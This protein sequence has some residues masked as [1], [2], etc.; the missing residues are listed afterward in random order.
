MAT[1]TTTARKGSTRS[2]KPKGGG[3][4]Q[5]PALGMVCLSSDRQVKFR[6]ITRS[7]FLSL[8]PAER[9]AQLREIYWCNV[10]ML[11]WALTYCAERDIR[12]YRATSA[13]FPM[14]DEDLGEALL[15]GMASTM[16]SVGR[17]AERLGIRV[18]LHPDQFVV[19][20]SEAE[21]VRET[22]RKVMEKHALAFD[23]LGLERSAWNLMNVHGGKAGR[24]DELVEAIEALPENVRSRLT[25]E[26]DEYSFS[27]AQILDVCRRA[28]VPFVF[29]CHHHVIKECLD[30]YDHPSV[31]EMTAAA[32][33]T[34]PKAAWQLCHISNGHAA[35]LDRY[36][37]EHITIAPGAFRDVPWLE[38][39]ARGKEQAILAL[40]AKWP[41]RA[42]RRRG[43]PLTKPTAAEKRAA[44]A[45]ACGCDD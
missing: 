34:W 44:E 13:L 26:N 27:S 24:A 36:H 43:E 18:V 40:H 1:T 25:L 9:E 6:T 35:F 3:N 7:R 20:N 23:L 16:S 21:R 14:S 33:E 31:A 11:H 2:K 12:L 45:E 28:G 5:R 32:R 8:E 15:C 41:R 19:L 30:S 22:S 38:V 10:Q 4:A 37:S 39:E 17:R 42:K 29:D